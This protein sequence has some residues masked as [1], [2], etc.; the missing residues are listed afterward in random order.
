[1]KI[2]KKE[3]EKNKQKILAIATE[4]FIEFGYQAVSLRKIAKLAGISDATIYHYFPQKELL[5]VGIFEKVNQSVF[6]R[7]DSF[8]AFDSFS[9]QEKFHLSMEFFLEELQKIKGF[10]PEGFNLLN[11][12]LMTHVDAL[13]TVREPI[14]LRIQNHIET[15][16]DQEEIPPQPVVP[17]LAN[18]ALNVM[19]SLVYFWLNDT[20][21]KYTKTTQCIDLSSELMVSLL[22]YNIVNKG[23]SLAAFLFRSVFL[24]GSGQGLFNM[25]KLVFDEFKTYD[26]QASDV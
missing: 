14:V 13:K 1:M 9:L 15:A 7:I 20:S 17:L 6:V 11:R 12:Y 22:K 24:Q 21:P 8:S 18:S 2:S 16:I 5:L 10:L 4:Q 23:L 26:K 25:A 19:L 3:K